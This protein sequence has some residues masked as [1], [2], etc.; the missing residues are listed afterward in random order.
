MLADQHVVRQAPRI[1]TEF[2]Q[3]LASSCTIEAADLLRGDLTL[4]EGADLERS[5][6]KLSATRWTLHAVDLGDAARA[7][8]MTY[9]VQEFMR[10]WCESAAD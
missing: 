9:T 5:R 1:R 3:P 4:D 7:E 10:A 2:A 6:T 8:E